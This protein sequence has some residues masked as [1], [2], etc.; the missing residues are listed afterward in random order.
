[1][2]RRRI[3][4]SNTDRKLSGVCGGLA[5]FLGVDP[6]IVRVAWVLIS[7]FTG[8]GIPLGVIAYVICAVVIPN[9]PVY[10]APPSDW[11]E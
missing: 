3:Y 9:A 2:E 5:Q 11:Q 1:V 6:T 8:V 4:K 10:D 7:L